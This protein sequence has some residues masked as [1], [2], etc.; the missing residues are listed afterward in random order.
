[1]IALLLA[2][3]LAFYDFNVMEHVADYRGLPRAACM[4]AADLPLGT[5]LRIA[6]P[7]GAMDCVVVD[8]PEARDLADIRRRGIVAEVQPAAFIALCGALVAPRDCRVT[9]M[10]MLSRETDHEGRR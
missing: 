2:G 1:M 7:R 9:V 4:A 6:G 3:F 8:V 5:R 10:V